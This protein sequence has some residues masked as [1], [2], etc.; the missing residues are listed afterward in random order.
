MDRELDNIVIVGGGT[1][2]WLSALFAQSKFPNSNITLIESNN[3]PIIGVGESTQPTFIHVL[4]YLGIPVSRLV[5]ECST[6]IKNS[7]KFTNWSSNGESYYHNFFDYDRLQILNPSSINPLLL[8]MIEQD[9]PIPFRTTT[10]F[11]DTNYKVPAIL[12]DVKDQRNKIFDFNIFENYA[13]HIHALEIVD[14]FK[15]IANERGIK[16]IEGRVIDFENNKYDEIS[17]IKLENGTIIKSDFI[18][19]CS[20]LTRLIIGKYYKTEWKSYSDVL[21]VNSAIPFQI[22]MEEKI[23]PYTEAVAMKYGW[24]WRIPLQN[25]YGCGYVFDSKYISDDEAK[26]EIEEYLGYK[27]EYP[28]DSSIKFEA[29]LYKETWTKNCVAIGLAAGFIEP[30]EATSIQSTVFA[31]NELFKDPSSLLRRNKIN[32]KLY[33][34]RI[35]KFNDEIANFINL[36][37]ITD[38]TDTDFWKQF[39]D[40][41][42][43]F[44]QIKNLIEQ[45]KYEVPSFIQNNDILFYRISSWI[46]VADGNNIINKNLIKQY[47]DSV[48]GLRDYCTREYEN[49]LS[50]FISLVEKSMDHR[51]F[52]EYLKN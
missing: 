10:D 1:A 46:I 38:R 24:I 17:S 18:L 33:N 30:L 23:P 26:Q 39:Q 8:F 20:G 5:K 40:T 47:L 36:H 4:D 22:E 25:R 49:F 7:I 21:T 3:V 19:D 51:E 27:P 35:I 16:R 15:K 42:K 31:L 32:A 12:T 29:G 45:W 13:I 28:R 41:S 52:L 37:Y 50:Q 43:S 34:K 2:G 9:L 44:D 6:T 11:L 48:P 14:L